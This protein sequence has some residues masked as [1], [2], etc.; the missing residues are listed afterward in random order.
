MRQIHF[1]I[2]TLKNEDGSAIIMALLTLAVL[3]VIGITSAST[4]RVELTVVRNEQIYQ[5]NFYQAESCANE[6]AYYI[7]SEADT[8]NLIPDYSDLG[9]M[10][11]NDGNLDLSDSGN[12]VSTGDED[13]DNAA[14]SQVGN[15]QNSNYSAIAKGPRD[16]S[17]L[18]IGSSRLYEF[19]AYGK[20]ESYN[21]NAVVEVGY[22]KRF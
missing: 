6:A 9:W 5:I 14:T 18:D 8:S 1:S 17:S 15:I 12:W 20:S 3:T 22:L 4:S 2:H 13:N 7:E 19:A 11:T 10:N 16:G 21:G